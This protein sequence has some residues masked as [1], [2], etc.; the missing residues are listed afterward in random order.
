[1]GGVFKQKRRSFPLESI[2]ID[3][4]PEMF[5]TLLN[6]LKAKIISH[7]SEIRLALV[8]K[9]HD[10]LKQEKTEQRLGHMT[11]KKEIS[12]Y[13]VAIAREESVLFDETESD[14]DE[15]RITYMARQN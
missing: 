3:A 9:R 13:Q 6:Y 11:K 1:M 15:E 8:F 2:F 12:P 14:K 4:F 10:V 5:V 7:K